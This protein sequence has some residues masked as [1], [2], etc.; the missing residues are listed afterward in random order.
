MSNF[1]DDWL[2][3]WDKI[4]LEKKQAKKAIHSEELQ[5]LRTR[6]DF[7]T[8]LLAAPETGFRTW[9]TCTLISEIP[10]GCHTGKHSHGEEGIYVVKG[11]GFSIVN[12]QRYDWDE[13]SCIHIPF[14][15][16]HQHF[17]TGDTTVVYYSALAPHLEYL[18]AV[19]RFQQFEDCGETGKIPSDWIQKSE[20]DSQGRL[21]VLR[22]SDQQ[23]TRAHEK[24]KDAPVTEFTKTEAK[25]MHQPEMDTVKGHRNIH[26]MGS[27]K[28][29]VGEEV[30]LTTVFW[31]QKGQ[32]SQNHAHMEAFLYVLEGE[33]YSVVDGEKVPWKKGTCYHIQG[34]QTQHQHFPQSE[35][36]LL[37]THFGIRSR[38]FQ[39][40]AKEAFP[41]LYYS[42]GSGGG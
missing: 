22:A 15:A 42:H 40:I 31:Y 32:Y 24:P 19:A 10:P 17:N 30:E 12:D 16:S 27:R 2:G 6:Q 38:F 25:E 14:G 35:A 3:M 34:P 29:F 23:L 7:K 13:G 39:P 1:Y 33:G 26:L 11:N 41:Y 8:A 37:R 18:C 5:W 28:D 4:G 21:I 20:H 9:G 36:K